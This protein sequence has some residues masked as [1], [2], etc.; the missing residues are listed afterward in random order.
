L[1]RRQVW[2][3]WV[4]ALSLF[5]S[6][7]ALS[8]LEPDEAEEADNAA[9]LAPLPGAG[10]MGRSIPGGGGIAAT[11]A[12]PMDLGRSFIMETAGCQHTARAAADERVL[13]LRALGPGQ[14]IE[15]QA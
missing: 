2:H 5:V 14:V 12:C 10:W 1:L 6:P 13:A 7:L 4:S 11:G 15:I 8:Q 3:A 9:G